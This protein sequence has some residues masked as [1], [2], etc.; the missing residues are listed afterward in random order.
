LY[1]GVA[2][3]LECWTVCRAEAYRGIAW[4]SEPVTERGLQ[5]LTLTGKPDRIL[6]RVGASY[7]SLPHED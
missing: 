6:A 2:D 4:A 1:V 7:P 5:L 3:G